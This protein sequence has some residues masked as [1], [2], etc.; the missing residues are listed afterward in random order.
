MDVT[1]ILQ[2]FN[3][4]EHFHKSADHVHSL[5]PGNIYSGSIPI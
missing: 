2:M 5:Q 3:G 4:A 1:W